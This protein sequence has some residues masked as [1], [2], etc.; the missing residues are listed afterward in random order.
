[1]LLKFCE[2]ITWENFEISEEYLKNLLE[3][4]KKKLFNWRKFNN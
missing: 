4:L 1:M 2:K 3:I